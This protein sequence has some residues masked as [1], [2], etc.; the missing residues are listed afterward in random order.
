MTFRLL[1]APMPEPVAGRWTAR[2]SRPGFRDRRPQPSD[3]PSTPPPVTHAGDRAGT[4][5][6]L[7][8]ITGFRGVGA[9]CTATPFDGELNAGDALSAADQAA[10]AEPEGSTPRRKRTRR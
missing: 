1:G 10:A 4:L 2:G 8:T 6:T 9:D 5:V 7:S 3:S